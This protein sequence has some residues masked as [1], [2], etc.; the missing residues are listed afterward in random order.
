MF[1]LDKVVTN[2]HKYYFSI[3]TMFQNIHVP[4][5]KRPIK[6]GGIPHNTVT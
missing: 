3:I 1:N 5:S 4:N 6:D 2:N